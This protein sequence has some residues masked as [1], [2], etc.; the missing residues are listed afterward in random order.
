[1]GLFSITGKTIKIITTK[2]N[3]IIYEI[4]ESIL[5]ISKNVDVRT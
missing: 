2:E 1:M 3:G 4:Y 5:I